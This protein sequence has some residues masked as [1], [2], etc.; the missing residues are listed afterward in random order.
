MAKKPDVTK[1][2]SAKLLASLLSQ[3]KSN[4]SEIAEL[5]GE[6]GQVI[7]DAV[8]KHN[9]HAAAFKLAKKLAGYDAVKLSAFLVHF[10]DYRTKLELDKMAGDPLPMEEPE[11]EPQR[12]EGETDEQMLARVAAEREERKRIS[13]EAN[14]GGQTV[15]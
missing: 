1:L 7:A 2:P 4:A 6:Y 13:D 3:S 14:G 10:D 15:N 12:L 5:K 11:E 9:L 8:S